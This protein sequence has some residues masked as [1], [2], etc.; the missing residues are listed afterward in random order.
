MFKNI[1]SLVLLGFILISC[2]DE[3]DNINVN[4]NKAEKPEVAYLLTGSLK[5]GADLYWGGDSNYGSTLLFVQ[6]WAEI[7]YTTIDRY[8]ISNASSVVTTL[9]NKGYATLITD[10]NTIFNL[11]DEQANVNYKGVALTLRSWVFLLLTDA[12]GDV[13]YNEVGKNITPAYNTQ[14]EV[15]IGILNDLSQALTLLDASKAGIAGDVVYNGDITKWRK[16]ANSLRLRIALRI[17]DREDQLAKQTITEVI[18]DPAGLIDN[19]NDI[20]RFVYTK[21]PQHNPQAATFDTRDDYRI[22]KTIV[23]KLKSLSDPRLPIYAQL[24]ADASVTDYVGGAN[25][26]SNGDAA[27]QGFAKVS[28]P[29][30]YFLTPE[31][32]AVIYSYAE[33]LFNLSEAVARGYIPGNAED[34]YNQAIT[35]SFNQFGIT[36]SAVIAN[37][38]AQ[39]SVKYDASNYK[40]SI[41]EQKWIAFFGQ[42]PDAFAEWR[43]LDYPQLV[44][45]PASTLG[46]KIPVR[47][48]YPG[49]EQSLNGE[50]YKKA[51]DNQKSDPDDDF[52]LLT[53][54][55]WFDVY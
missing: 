29:G 26:L 20:F 11:P 6:H 10:L 53:N 13:P 8:S 17:A 36:N 39:P 1:V 30:I 23:D 47:F 40:K 21:S 9:W 12:Y 32:P 3:L 49:T 16:F 34:Y 44:A 24:P 5:Q 48:F 2:N 41:G 51:V 38:L 37:Y 14:K 7:Q 28:K 35:A 18:N 54:K 52:D 19:N 45:G 22:S 43:R 46:G 15:Y 27:N 4:P 42:G 50:N 55:L 31:A 25:G 33:I